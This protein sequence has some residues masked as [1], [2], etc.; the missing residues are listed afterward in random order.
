MAVPQREEVPDDGQR[1]DARKA[2]EVHI[3]F[4]ASLYKGQPGAGRYFVHEHP[5]WATSWSA[6]CIEKIAGHPEV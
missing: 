5:R 1:Q 2:A 6:E 4:V 3:G